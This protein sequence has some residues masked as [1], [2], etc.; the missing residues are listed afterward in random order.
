M[1]QIK[2]DIEQLISRKLA[3]EL[4]SADEQRLLNWIA[5]SEENAIAY[6]KAVIILG[7]QQKQLRKSAVWNKVQSK[8]SMKQTG[9]S[10]RISKV[11]K[12]AAMFALILLIPLALGKFGEDDLGNGF[13]HTVKGNDVATS[14]YLPDGSKVILSRGS[15]ISYNDG[16]NQSNREL[17]LKGKAYI[18]VDGKAAHLPLVVSAG[19]KCAIARNGKL[20]IDGKNDRFDVAVE[21]GEATIV[22]TVYKKV[23]IPMFKLTPAKKIGSEQA[24][25]ISEVTKVTQ[26]QRASYSST[27]EMAKTEVGSY[28]E[29]FSWKDKVF[30]FS[31]LKQHELARKVSEW[32][33]KSVE[34]KG[35][36][37]PYKNYSGSFDDPMVKD[38]IKDIFGSDVKEIKESK[39]KITVV[40]S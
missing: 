14:F 22:D 29:V 4:S 31:N 33:G 26:G 12:I 2:A 28:C 15:E 13:V 32:Y 20:A 30:C 35:D 6:E 37:D 23:I 39:R 8:S 38:L 36:L 25:V 34:F 7:R 5:E 27:D 24:N 11:M 16:Y 17:R 10:F 19:K 21:E 40:F 18:E 1:A 3:G 9:P